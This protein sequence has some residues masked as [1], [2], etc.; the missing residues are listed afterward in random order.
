M[1]GEPLSALKWEHAVIVICLTTLIVIMLTLIYRVTTRKG[2]FTM[3]TLE[4]TNGS[5]CVDIKVLKLP[6]CPD[7]Y[8]IKLPR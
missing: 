8:I 6:A 3:I 2:T 4:I 1:I 7:F 5:E